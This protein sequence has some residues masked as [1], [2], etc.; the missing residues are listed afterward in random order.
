MRLGLT[1][2]YEGKNYDI[3]ELPPEAF[4]HLVPSLNFDQFRRIDEYFQ[5]VWPEPTQRRHHVLAFAAELTGASI[6]YLLLH[7]ECI[8]FD[9]HDLSTYV[10]E[11]TKQV[12]RPS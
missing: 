1:I 3:L 11:H 10:M 6:D 9:D 8:H 4:V 7:R 2:E 12:H 5:A